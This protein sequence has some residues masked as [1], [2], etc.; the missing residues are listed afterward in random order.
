M[1]NLGISLAVFASPWVGYAL[2]TLVA[3]RRRR[4]SPLH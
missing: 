3:R 4:R 1:R 2:W